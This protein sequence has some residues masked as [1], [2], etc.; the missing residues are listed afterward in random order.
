MLYRRQ[1]DRQ[2]EVR[3]HTHLFDQS[4][5]TS[6]TDIYERRLWKINRFFLREE[7]PTTKMEITEVAVGGKKVSS[8]FQTCASFTD[9]KQEAATI[10][11]RYQHAWLR[12]RIRRGG[13]RL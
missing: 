3:Q 6:E 12:R 10:N 4:R 2:T 11:T 1:A 8:R 5:S 9:K 7:R 13:K